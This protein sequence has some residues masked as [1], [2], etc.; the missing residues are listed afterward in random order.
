MKNVNAWNLE[1]F[2]AVLSASNPISTEGSGAGAGRAGRDLHG[3][4]GAGAC[5]ARARVWQAAGR[6][7]VRLQ[8]ACAVTRGDDADWRALHVSLHAHKAL[9]GRQVSARAQSKERCARRA[10]VS[11][12]PG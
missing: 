12:K 3:A 4:L 1:E 5:C 10:P 2:F 8:E 6:G 9:P 11:V 7:T